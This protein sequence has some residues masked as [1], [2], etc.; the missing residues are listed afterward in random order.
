PS[1][2]KAGLANAGEVWTLRDPNQRTLSV[3]PAIASKN[4]GQSLARRSAQAADS[5][6][7][8]GPHAAP[9][10]SPGAANTV[11]EP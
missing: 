5:S 11:T 8:F 3:F 2:G 9:G 1:L 7:S 10:A 4:G 6:S